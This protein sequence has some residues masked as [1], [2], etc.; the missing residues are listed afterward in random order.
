MVLIRQFQWGLRKYVKDLLLTLPDA[1][2][3]SEAIT[4]AVRCD[5]RLFLRKQERRS[6]KL[7]LQLIASTTSI[8]SRALSNDIPL[9]NPMHLDV[10][11]FK[12]LIQEEKDCRWK[13]GLCLYCRE[14][15]HKASNCFKKST[16][17]CI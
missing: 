1:T 5:N 17:Q 14:P 7:N 4:Q 8:P 12:P 3:L 15:R 6:N 16:K 9:D 11:R 10:T 2:T 13:E